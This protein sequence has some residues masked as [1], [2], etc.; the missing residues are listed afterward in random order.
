MVKTRKH[1]LFKNKSRKQKIFKL[2]GGLVIRGV[3]NWFIQ[4][5]NECLGYYWLTDPEFSRYAW[6]KES[7]VKFGEKYETIPRREG[8]GLSFTNARKH[9]PKHP[10]PEGRGVFV[11]GGGEHYP[12]HLFYV[13]NKG[14]NP[15]H[16]SV[17]RLTTFSSLFD[18]DMRS[19]MGPHL[20]FYTRDIP[21]DG[22]LAG[23]SIGSNGKKID[24]FDQTDFS[25][26]NL[27]EDINTIIQMDR[28]GFNL[29][30]CVICK[31]IERYVANQTPPNVI[32]LTSIIPLLDNEGIEHNNGICVTNFGAPD[33]RTW[34]E[35]K[36]EFQVKKREKDRIETERQK[37]AAHQKH[38]AKSMKPGIVS[39]S[40][41]P[42]RTHVPRKQTKAQK[43]AQNT[44]DQ[45]ARNAA[46][47]LEVATVSEL[48]QG[49]SGLTFGN[50]EE[51]DSEEDDSEDEHNFNF[52][53][54]LYESGKLHNRQ[55]NEFNDHV[56]KFIRE[57]VSLDKSTDEIMTRL[58]QLCNM[59]VNTTGV[60]SVPFSI[61]AI[62]DIIKNSLNIENDINP[63]SYKDMI[64]LIRE[65]VGVVADE[66]PVKVYD[67]STEKGGKRRT[68]R[69]TNRRR[70]NRRRTNR[71]R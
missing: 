35:N 42:T 54:E 64:H 53:V 25:V 20:H 29:T 30:K 55:R 11:L 66:T 65:Y 57:F 27:E 15:F 61:Q 4:L 21:P 63:S 2:V 26:E 10:Y 68:N 3:D 70:T 34:T 47:K 19:P 16:V 7:E 33:I 22:K 12:D 52:Y 58:E 40:S 17:H 51:D 38:I 71:R 6:T 45:L 37:E 43:A 56:F 14:F 24:F 44:R 28:H 13:Q 48:S 36:R 67:L 1:G 39:I 59:I 69:R 5:I 18:W 32:D 31:L 9:T 41:R 23:F 50:S 46:A 62:F 8:Y 49:I 60:E